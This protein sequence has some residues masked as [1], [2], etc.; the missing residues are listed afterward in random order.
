MK[1]GI[2]TSYFVIL[3]VSLA[4]MPMLYVLSIGPV[5]SLAD[6]NCLPLWFVLPLLFHLTP[7]LSGH[8]PST[9]L[10]PRILSCGDD[11]QWATVEQRL[12]NT[13]G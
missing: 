1:Q 4:L 9:R 3:L 11:E 8:L 12:S 13:A 2:R 5:I 7:W 10:W 6:R